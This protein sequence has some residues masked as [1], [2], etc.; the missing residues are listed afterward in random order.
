[1]HN[2]C[3]IFIEKVNARNKI[4]AVHDSHAKLIQDIISIP[5]TPTL[6][7]CLPLSNASKHLNVN[8]PNGSRSIENY[9]N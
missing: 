4:L 3:F 8:V 5:N 7:I 2:R 6:K 9:N 1:M